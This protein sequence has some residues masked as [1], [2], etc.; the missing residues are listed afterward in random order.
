LVKNRYKGYISVEVFE[1]D[2]DLQTIASLSIGYLKGF[3][4]HWVEKA[5]LREQLKWVKL[6][7]ESF[8]Y[9]GERLVERKEM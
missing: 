9:W 2:P 6:L 8:W 4:K 3:W 7:F 5:S 1:F